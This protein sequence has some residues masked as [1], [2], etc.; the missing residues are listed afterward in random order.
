MRP[1]DRLALGRL[2]RSPLPIKYSGQLRDR[3]VFQHLVVTRAHEAGWQRFTTL[4]L[5]GLGSIDVLKVHQVSALAVR[6]A[7]VSFTEACS[8]D[9]LSAF[10][11]FNSDLNA[12]L[13]SSL[14]SDCASRAVP[15][16]CSKFALVFYVNLMQMGSTL[17]SA[18][19][20]YTIQHRLLT[21]KTLLQTIM[22]RIGQ[23]NL[24][25]YSSTSKQP[26]PLSLI[27]L[28]LL[29]LA[30]KLCLPFR[31]FLFKLKSINFSMN[32]TQLMLLKVN[33]CVL[34]KSLRA[35][36][37]SMT[38]CFQMVCGV[39]MILLASSQLPLLPLWFLPRLLLL[40]NLLLSL[41]RSIRHGATI[42]L[43]ISRL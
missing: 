33:S 18:D 16:R 24:V 35:L 3:H 38:L 1:K 42:T 31:S 15:Y 25:G 7:S 13:L 40:S 41:L 32:G 9:D 27:T 14:S 20:T 19:V 2:L 30:S 17:P 28:T 22:L 43:P 4:S 34:I 8:S 10:V 26:A 36:P 12:L 39:L 6:D 29:L 23:I 11:Q 37:P 21:T 5:P